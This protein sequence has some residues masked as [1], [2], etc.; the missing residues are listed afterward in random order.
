MIKDI[1]LVESKYGK[2]D[3]SF[4]G[5]DVDTVIGNER[6]I[7]AVKHSILL[8]YG[9]LR[10]KLYQNKGSQLHYYIPCTN[11]DNNIEFIQEEIKVNCTSIDGISDAIVSVEAETLGIKIKELIV[12][13]DDGR[14]VVVIGG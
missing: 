1:Q 14:E 10:Q 5:V 13:R 7:N 6:I 8:K 12:T 2:Y 4:N 9:E 11:N 3:W